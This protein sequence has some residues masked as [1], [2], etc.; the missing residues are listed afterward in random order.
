L[1]EH[2]RNFHSRAVN[3]QSALQHKFGNEIYHLA[4]LEK[5][6]L[7]L[8][9]FHA[10]GGIDAQYLLG[11]PPA[12]N[13]D[14]NV[15]AIRLFVRSKMRDARDRKRNV[16]ETQKYYQEQYNLPDIWLVDALDDSVEHSDSLL[17]AK[18][19]L[20]SSDV[21]RI[22]PQA[23]IIIF[24]ECFNGSF[25]NPGYVAGTY[26]FGNGTTIAGVANSVNVKQDIWSDE[27]LGVLSY[28]VRIGEWHRIRTYLESHLFGD[29][30]FRFN[31][32]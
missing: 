17:A 14:E 7:D 16:E 15:Q 1:R 8:A 20:Y 12:Q 10:H 28:G 22:A 6:E 18:L 25:I 11:Y 29:P 3:D 24:D 26:L 30:T 31:G 2:S 32:E 13:I 21:A 19:D 27:L 5:S 9:I 4:E 23:E